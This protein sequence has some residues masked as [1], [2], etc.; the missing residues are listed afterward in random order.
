M[1]TAESWWELLI[2]QG[3]QLSALCQP[4]RWNGGAGGREDWESGCMC[5]CGWIHGYVDTWIHLIH[6]TAEAGT[7]LWSNYSSIKK[8][9]YTKGKDIPQLSYSTL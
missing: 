8:Y 5:T 7:V 3:A 6:C 1:C 2:A 4:R 9:I